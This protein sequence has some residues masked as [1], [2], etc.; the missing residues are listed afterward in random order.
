[1]PGIESI[2]EIDSDDP[3]EI[4][5]EIDRRIR[6]NFLSVDDTSEAEAVETYYVT[7][8]HACDSFGIP[9]GVAPM[10]QP[11]SFSDFRQLFADT[12]VAMDRKYVDLLSARKG[13]GIVLDETWRAKIHAYLAII[14]GI[15][16]RAAIDPA[17]KDSVL[18]RLNALGAEVDRT[19]TRVQKF[20]D[21][22][23]GLC[24]AVG[25]GAKELEPAVKL[26]ERVAGA[27]E[28]LHPKPVTLALPAPETLGLKDSEIQQLPDQTEAA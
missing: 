9:F 10:E 5:I 3:L 1:M 4:V 24:G 6:P 28:R 7:I 11:S 27:L 20:G 13:T 17:L 18:A 25:A 8:K 21:V 22:L 16:D 26:L 19:R 14:R 2:I 15:V 12:K 23:I